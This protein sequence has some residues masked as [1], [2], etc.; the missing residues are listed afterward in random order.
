MSKSG[1]KS[2]FS[3]WFSSLPRWRK[4]LYCVIS[5]TLVAVIIATSVLAILGRLDDTV[6]IITNKYVPKKAEDPYITVNAG[7]TPKYPTDIEVDPVGATLIAGYLRNGTDFDAE[8][9]DF[10]SRIDSAI[11]SAEKSGLNTL[12]VPL[13]D[14]GKAIYG[15][16]NDALDYIINAAQKKSI[17]VY[18]EF[19]L[20]AKEKG[21]Y[22]ISDDEDITTVT[23]E[24]NRLVSTYALSG[25][26][27]TDYYTSL[28]EAD[29]PAYVKSG[30]GMGFDAFLRDRLANAVDK[31][32]SSVK[33]INSGIVFGITADA[34]W[35]SADTVEGGIE[36]KGD[37][38]ESLSDGHA[39]TVL[40]LNKNY[41]DCV[42]VSIP[43]S[44]RDANTPFGTVAEWWA[45]MLGGRTRI[46]F[47]LAAYNIGS[48]EIWDSPNQMADQLASI[49]SFTA[50][51]YVFD[52]IKNL[53][54][55]K[56]GNIKNAIEYLNSSD[57]M[58]VKELSFTSVYSNKFTTYSR[59][60][61]FTGASDPEHELTMNGESVKRTARGYFSFNVTLKEGENTFTFTHKDKT[62]V[63]TVTYESIIIKRVAPKADQTLNGNSVISV[64][65]TARSGSTVT[66]SL[67]GKTVK[68][69]QIGAQDND[70]AIKQEFFDF[71]GVFVL[72]EAKEK[73]QN[74]GPIEFYA[75]CG[76]LYDN[77][78]GG[79]ITIRSKS[80]NVT[81]GGGNYQS[82]YGIQVGVGT[83]YVAEVTAPQ[84]ETLDGSLIDERSRPTN[85]YL[86][87]GT[88][89]Y[90]SEN[91]II[92]YNS[93]TSDNA[94]FRQLDYGKRVYSDSV[95]VFK[96]TLPE[97]NSIT[98]KSTE[99]TG[100][101]TVMTFDT[102][103]KAPFN[104][105]LSSQHYE[106]PYK[107]NSMPDYT[108]DEAT[109]SYID[110][111]FCYTVSAQGKI[112]LDNNPVFS[113]GEWIKS[114]G[115]YVLRL[116]LKETGKFYGWTAQYNEN[117]QLEFYFLNPAKISSANNAYGY[118]LDG[119]V[120]MLDP[121]HG[122]KS[123]PGAVGSNEQNTEAVLN[124]FLAKKIQRELENIGAT[125]IMTHTT[126]ELFTLY[127]RNKLSNEVKPDIF[128]SIHRN[129]SSSTSAEGYSNFYFHPFSKQLA[130]AVY[131]RT[132]D[133]FYDRRGCQYYPFYVTR[134]SCCPA[135]LT[136]NGFMTN[137]LD[138][139]RIQT[140]SH[141]EVNA[142]LTVQGIVDYFV[143][144]Q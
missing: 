9:D 99:S 125:V 56:T 67:N 126:N 78:K 74:L 141:N 29:Y 45:N 51:G 64:S 6:D 34:I 49:P 23:A 75:S 52:S 119:V 106:N 65:V 88:I 4:L 128:I 73:A 109:Y 72:P 54:E 1:K 15:G 53:V 116:H 104:V 43:H 131:N 95:S 14:G 123:D 87:A 81:S 133:A 142:Y 35:A 25:I 55:D 115:N 101:H 132:V 13:N 144:I 124:L 89:D 134:I 27:I 28:G 3:R 127:E 97:T 37:V 83:R 50:N 120:I 94:S 122:G 11:A 103:W 79:N 60:L 140:D 138:F 58:G 110:I 105:T 76:S 26:T 30:S 98:L 17:A 66:A 77:A 102:N 118:R 61:S 93:S 24:I 59:N 12:I 68:L 18:G 31:I 107:P 114:G 121:G 130:Q 69:A 44:T 57:A 39:D 42:F 92:F 19:S 16:Q 48:G 36:C 96:A 117:N 22:L 41:A 137:A 85:A 139:A 90:C 47:T 20:L 91:E 21:R 8:S 70:S 71:T 100:R 2:K 143:S 86:P 7:N 32:G 111:E 112:I 84:A 33:E 129:G 62:R 80:N 10:K 46:N 63:F 135:I 108:I 40:W 82:G 5:S 113:K 38:F 136:E